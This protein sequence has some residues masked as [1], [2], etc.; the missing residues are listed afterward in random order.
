M[1]QSAS[2]IVGFALLVFGALGMCGLL[3]FYAV[4]LFSEQ[5]PILEKTNQEFRLLFGIPSGLVVLYAFFAVLGIPF[6]IAALYGAQ[7]WKTK[8]FI[9][10]TQTILLAVIWF[11]A[12]LLGFFTTIVQVQTLITRIMPFSTQPVSFDVGSKIPLSVQYVFKVSLKNEVVRTRGVPKEGYEP[13]MF[14]VAFPGL[15]ATDFEGVEAS[16]GHYTIE[17]GKLVHKMDEKRLIHSAAKAITDRGLDRLLTNVSVRLG[18]DLTKDGTLTEV[19]AALIATPD[20]V[21]GKTQSKVVSPRANNAAV[22]CTEEAKI[23]PDGSAVGRHGPKCEFTACPTALP[24]TAHVCTSQEKQQKACTREYVPVCA[25]VSVQCITT[26][27]N[28]VPQTFSNACGACGQGHVISYT[29]GA[30]TL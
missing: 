12:I 4:V 30:C 20:T 9:T 5:W 23:C 13:S 15:T 3:F 6:F 18:V 16:I 21:T 25:L 29:K 11:I 19:M 2:Q 7:L 14:L 17:E 26:P 24:Q 22:A 8:V 10:K 27:C 1:K 28:P